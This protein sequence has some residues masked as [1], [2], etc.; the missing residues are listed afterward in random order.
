MHHLSKVFSLINKTGDRCIVLSEDADEAF[1]VM[2]LAEYERLTL[3]K[4][5]VASLTEDELLDKINRDIAVWK[6][7][8]PADSTD[9]DSAPRARE[10]DEPQEEPQEQGPLARHDWFDEDSWDEDEEGDEDPY[11][12]ET[13]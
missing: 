3:G 10:W 9:Y 4:S 13:V 12:F 5:E 6:S 11:Y 8:Q 2:S 7:R 1:A